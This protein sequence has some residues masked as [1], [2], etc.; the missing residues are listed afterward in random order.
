MAIR[1][2]IFTENTVLDHDQLH[3]IVLDNKTFLKDFLLILCGLLLFVVF[4]VF[5]ILIGQIMKDK[6]RASNIQSN[7][8]RNY[9]YRQITET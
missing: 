8:I 3:R 4:I 9:D 2:N 1:N 6:E 7:I 5:I